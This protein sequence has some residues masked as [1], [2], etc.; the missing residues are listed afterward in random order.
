MAVQET[1]V[2]VKMTEDEKRIWEAEAERRDMTRTG[3]LK[4]SERFFRAFDPEFLRAVKPA[5]DALKVSTP[6]AVVYLLNFFLSQQNALIE[7]FQKSGEED[8]ARALAQLTKARAFRYDENGLMDT[9]T[10]A[11]QVYK[12]VMEKLEGIRAKGQEAKRAGKKPE[13]TPEEKMVLSN[14]V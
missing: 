7:F 3:Y 9:D 14:L 8:A 12:E 4:E 1:Q 2:V 6:V 13:L 10:I 5:A 11:I